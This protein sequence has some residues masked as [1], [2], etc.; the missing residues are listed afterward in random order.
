MEKER[1]KRVLIVTET[2][3]G[4]VQDELT[5]CQSNLPSPL[6]L[7]VR[8]YIDIASVIM[9]VWFCGRLLWDLIY[10]RPNTFPPDRYRYW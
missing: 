1:I 6:M 3:L 2:R 5:A 8:Q 7:D 4:S 10:R 9:L